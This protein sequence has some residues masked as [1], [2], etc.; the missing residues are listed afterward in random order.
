MGCEWLKSLVCVRS[1]QWLGIRRRFSPCT[2]VSS[3]T[4]DWLVTTYGRNV[5][6]N[7]IQNSENKGVPS[8]QWD[9][10]HGHANTPGQ[11]EEGVLECPMLSAPS[12]RSDVKVMMCLCALCYI[13]FPFTIH[14]TIVLRYVHYSYMSLVHSRDLASTC[15]ACLLHRQF[16][17]NLFFWPCKNEEL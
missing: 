13:P 1:C 7:K 8:A 16:H 5:T 11:K 12:N 10:G 14:S 6:K 9:E 3:T 4:C 15:P 17:K 2:R